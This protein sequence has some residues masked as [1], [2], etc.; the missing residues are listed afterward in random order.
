[1]VDAWIDGR[2][3]AVDAAVAEAANLLA[4]SRLPVVAGLGTDIAGARAAIALAER[5]GG[6]VDHMH[7]DALLRDL[8]VARETGMMVTTPNEAALRADTLW[9]V[10]P[11]LIA[12]WPDLAAR[13]IARAPDP[14][15]VVDRRI[16]WLCPGSKSE[17]P[18]V[19]GARID[20]VGRDPKH[21]GAVLAALRARL[22]GRRCG[23]TQVADRALDA[24]SA[25]L[26]A[27]R[28]GVAV[29]SAAD[30]DALTVEMLCGVVND[31]NAATRFT[32]LPLAGGDNAT[33]VL[34]VCGWMTGFPMR[35]GFGRG[36]PEHDPWRFDVRRLVE[37]GET[38]CVLWI[39]A[40]RPVVPNW[41]R[42]VP[43]I[44]LAA[45]G[46]EFGRLPHVRIA[47]GRPGIDHDGVERIAATGAL[48]CVEARNPTGAMSVAQVVGRIAAAL[49]DG[50]TWPC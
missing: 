1:M 37:S 22:A 4:S 14:G 29:W 19:G 36:F 39:S 49:A 27:A 32:G 12:A 13:L 11:G 48:G 34:Q 17:M 8:D 20:T 2:P 38:D 21:L 10:G 44:A 50:R 16:F 42:E 41:N 33:G 3:A 15:L 25:G 26:A 28:F 9:M 23:R 30:L 5:V 47:V 31:L 6:A 46:S 43:T 35:T 40:Y 7:A 18:D 45:S 24:L